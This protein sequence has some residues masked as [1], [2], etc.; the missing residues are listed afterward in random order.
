[1][2]TICTG[3]QFLLPQARN[4]D[5][6]DGRIARWLRMLALMRAALGNQQRAG[7]GHQIGR[8]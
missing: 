7:W 8:S 3:S 1:M 5:P 6:S 2:T 4:L